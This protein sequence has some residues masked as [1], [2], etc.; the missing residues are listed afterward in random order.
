MS[1][2]RLNNIEETLAYQEQKIIDLSDMV[3]GQW[4]EIE[5]LTRHIERLKDKIVILEATSEEQDGES[6]S[7]SD[8]AKRDKPP[9]Y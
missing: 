4:E 2:T 6:L 8:I 3:A 7:V 1:E 5:K 9:H